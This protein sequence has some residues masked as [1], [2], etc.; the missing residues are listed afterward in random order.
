MDVLALNLLQSVSKPVYN[1]DNLS[2]YHNKQ[3][4]TPISLLN[5]KNKIKLANFGMLDFVK[6][7]N[8]K[9]YIKQIRN[10]T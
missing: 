7:F 2:Q 10:G 6:Y 4:C 8:D 5:D 3:D 9:K 1:V